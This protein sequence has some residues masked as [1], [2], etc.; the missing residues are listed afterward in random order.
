LPLGEPFGIGDHRPDRSRA[1]AHLPRHLSAA[2]VSLYR[3]TTGHWFDALV[4]RE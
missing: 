2:A 1:H 4:A 3:R